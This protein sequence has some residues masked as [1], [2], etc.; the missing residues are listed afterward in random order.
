[1]FYHIASKDNVFFF[2]ICNVSVISKLPKILKGSN[3][4]RLNKAKSPVDKSLSPDFTNI[5]IGLFHSL[6]FQYLPATIFTAWNTLVFMKVTLRS[7]SKCK[8]LSLNCHHEYYEEPSHSM[9]FDLS[10]VRFIGIWT[11]T[12]FS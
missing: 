3:V 2:G 12:Q 7:H 9:Q 5:Y 4:L 11:V 8:H 10:I 6:L 1:M